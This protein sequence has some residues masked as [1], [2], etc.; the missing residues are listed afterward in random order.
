MYHTEI[1]MSRV[2][3]HEFY[4]YEGSSTGL[5]MR[6]ARMFVQFQCPLLYSGSVFVRCFAL[7]IIS[8][9]AYHSIISIF[10]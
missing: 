6:H 1:P 4:E 3:N 8:R 5:D 7:A 10:L 9:D 2:R